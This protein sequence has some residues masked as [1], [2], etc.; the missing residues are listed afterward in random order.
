M[1]E[2]CGGGLMIEV[3]KLNDV[4]I[5]IKTDDGIARNLYD[6]FTFEVPGAKFMPS[7]R[8]KIWD[9]KI[10]LYNLK[11][12]TLYMGL[13]VPLIKWASKHGE[14]LTI[15][16][17]LKDIKDISIEDIEKFISMIKPTSKGVVLDVRDYQVNAIHHAIKFNRSLLLSPTASGKSLIIYLMVRFYNKHNVLI[18]VPTV[19]LVNQ[20]YSDF[21]DYGYDV[22]TNCHKIMAGAEKES[23]KRITI[24]T[25]QSLYKLPKGYFDKYGVIFGDEAHLF[26]AK[27]LTSIM[28]KL[29]DCK[30]RFGLTGSLD[31]SVCNKLILEGLF[32]QLKRV[33]TTKALIDKQHLSQFRIRAFVLK[34]K[35]PKGKKFD[36]QQELDYLVTN[37][38]R[39]NFI[40]K[41][42]LSLK[43][44]TL[45]LFQFVEK[46]GQVLQE[47]IKDNDKEVFYIHGG[48]DAT[49]REEIRNLVETKDN[50]IIVA[51]S[52]TM[53][54]GINIKN[55]HNIIFASP[56]K[57]R[58]RNLQSIGRG[59]RK[60]D[61]N[62]ITTLYDI[63]DDLQTKN[64]TLRH[65]VERIKLYNEE[66]F[67]YT[68]KKYELQDI[69]IN[70]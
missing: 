5:K 2:I 62:Q 59:L 25:W 61:N 66:Q 21:K 30:Y 29:T 10:K 63:A 64:Y 33:T 42:A 8:R 1:E 16:D 34:H 53:S 31:N 17:D 27:A 49:T 12:H 39:N 56:S 41:L 18:I 52:G 24:S 44:N 65:F 58:I 38:D 14:P 35:R 45:L 51:S 19:S 13:L 50:C 20:L 26:Q 7:V 22:E 36:Y 15:S 54:T 32:G 23:D 40:K 67:E 37:P 11:T 46:H 57:S 69:T 47:I 43:G 4:Y 28:T 3:T 70:Q 55:I 48:V 68:I 60:S 6:Y 9:G